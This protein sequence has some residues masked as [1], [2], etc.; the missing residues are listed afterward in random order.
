MRRALPIL[1]AIVLAGCLPSRNGSG[2]R[3]VRIVIHRD[4]IAFLPIRVAQTL[5]YYEAEGITIDVSE[6]AGGA[7]AIEALLGGSVDVA[8]ASLSDVMP[9]AADGRDV[10]GFLLLYTR[11][12]AALAVAPA[13]KDNIRTVRDLKG[14][15]VG[16]SAPGSWT[17]QFLNY[18]L[19]T[20]GIAPE[21]VSAV[22][23]GMSA[24]SVAALEHGTVDAAVLLAGAVSAFE[25]RHTNG[26]F[27]VDAWTPEGARQVFGTDVFPSLSLVARDRWLRADPDVAQRFVRAVKRGMQWVRDRPAEQVREMIPEPSRTTAAADLRSIR[28][29]QQEMSPDGQVPQGSADVVERFVAVT[30]AKVRAAH[31]DSAR[32]YTN[33][34]AARQ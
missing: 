32:I 17:H 14:R 18:L 28:R 3:V 30:N 20:N 4:P 26:C 11:P 6:V 24:S 15:T 34:F 12:S 10:R 1:L 8:A 9:L 23:V 19:I 7:K 22:S 16:V 25:D 21:E 5:G 31:V 13:M 29:M 27:I 33:E 2:I